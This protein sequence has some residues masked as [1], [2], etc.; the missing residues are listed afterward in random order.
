MTRAMARE[1]GADGITVNAI[2]PGPV[3]TEI[4]RKTVT[5]AQKVDLIARQCIAA[6]RS[7]P[8]SSAPCCFW[9]RTPRRFSPDRQSRSTAGR[10]IREGSAGAARRA[11]AL[12]LIDDSNAD[13]AHGRSWAKG[14][15]HDRQ[16]SRYP[17]RPP[18]II[19]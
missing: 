9:P 3:F 8:I 17:G 16:T 14:A 18:R 19:S 5:P 4:E 2:L 10:R 6:R 7:P 1:L 13:I 12:S 15:A 11:S